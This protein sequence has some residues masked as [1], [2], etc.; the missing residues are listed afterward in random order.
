MKST[1]KTI[2][3]GIQPSG[4]LHLGNY[5]GAI[6]QH[7]E[8]QEKG[9]AFYFIANYHSLTSLQDGK[10]LHD[11]TLDVALDYLALGMDPEKCTFF[12]QSDVPQ[13][14]ELSWILG[15]L[16]PVSLMEKGV[17]YKDKIAQ[18]LQPNIGLFTYPVLQAADILIY[19][20]DIVPVG[21]DQKQNIEI[22]RDL[23]ARFN[24]VYGGEYLRIPEPYIVESVATVPGVDGRK[25]SKSYDNTIE[26][27]DS[28]K[29]LKKKVMSVVTDSKALEEPKD[30][31][32]C[33]VFALI[34]LFADEQKIREV[35]ENYLSGGYGYG[36]AKKELLA[37]VSDYF[38]E[39]RDA[40]HELAKDPDT[41]RDMLREG[42]R[43][44]RVRAESVMEP[45][46]EVAGIVRHVST[47]T[48]HN[49]V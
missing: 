36:H 26:I 21:A 33:N 19:G 45:V 9:D 16:T 31:D 34:K 37:L 2:L 1:K 18:G 32:S 48:T 15:T 27:F 20:S 47:S 3:S 14:L 6:R 30:P 42:G 23:A 5:F 22:S 24:H 40:R 44:A 35:R 8:F 41:V 43:K 17:S 25:M 12:A 39:A 11:Y 46:R 28:G 49:L 29:A 38:K 13:V 7:L 4:R 10:K